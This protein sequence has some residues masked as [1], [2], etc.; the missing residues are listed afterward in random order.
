MKMMLLPSAVALGLGFAAGTQAADA[1]H[2]QAVFTVWCTGCHEPLPGRSYAPPAG[3][4][5]LQ[6][7]Y[8]GRIPSALEQRTDLTANQ[9]RTT[10]RN[11][12]NM[13]PQTRR[14]EVSDA[15]LDD[16]IAY[17]TQHNNS[18]QKK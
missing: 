1:A 14:T 10:V 16:V 17:L 5:V 13:M 9:I 7:H 3:S 6:Q 2:G 12:R 8:Q 11:G 18:Q 15:D 4:Y